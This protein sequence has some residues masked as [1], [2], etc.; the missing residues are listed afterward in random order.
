MSSFSY[1]YKHT[2]VYID[3]EFF[4]AYDLQTLAIVHDIDSVNCNGDCT[5]ICVPPL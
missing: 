3:V 5:E 2:I 4:L 1:A